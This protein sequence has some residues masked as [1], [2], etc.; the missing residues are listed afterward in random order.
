[1]PITGLLL[2]KRLTPASVV[3]S[4]FSCA[5]TSGDSSATTPNEIFEPERSS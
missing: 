1:M 2:S 5:V 3:A 4:G